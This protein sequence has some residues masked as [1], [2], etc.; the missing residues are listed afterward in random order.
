MAGAGAARQNELLD[1][2]YSHCRRRRGGGGLARESSLFES[3]FVFEELSSGGGLSEGDRPRLE[4]WMARLSGPTRVE[5]SFSWPVV[6][7]LVGL[8][9]RD[10]PV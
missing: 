2:Q 6:E 7:L 3:I 4:E 9:L 10:G 5:C 8:T 1:Y